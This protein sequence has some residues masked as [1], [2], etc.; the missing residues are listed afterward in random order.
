MCS[1]APLLPGEV[2]VRALYY[3]AHQPRGLV[4]FALVQGAGQLR[5]ELERRGANVAGADNSVL[6]GIR[7][8]ASLLT[9]GRLTMSP[10]CRHLRQQFASYVWDDKA[11]LSG[12]DRPLKVNDHAPDA[13]RYAIYSE[14]SHLLVAPRTGKTREIANVARRWCR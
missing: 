3:L 4:G 1:A 10:Q 13:L 7:V 9:D 11:A 12:Q 8:V 5:V 2:L 6:D 14:F